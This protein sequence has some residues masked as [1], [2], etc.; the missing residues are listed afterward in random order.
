MSEKNK[1]DEMAIKLLE[2][3][4]VKK[5]EIAKLSGRPHYKTNMTFFYQPLGKNINL[6]VVADNVE[7]AR[8]Y[9]YLKQQ[10]TSIIDAYKDLEFESEM[11]S[12]KL[13]GFTIEEWKEDFKTRASIINIRVKK[14]KLKEMEAK[15]DKIV[16]KEKRDELE[17]ELL[18]KELL[19]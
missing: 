2:V 7:L 5:E 4:K 12:P 13:D 19:G 6:N 9:G 8:Y 15:I 3:V 18:S 14:E 11:E 1:N 10:A 16:S 17:L